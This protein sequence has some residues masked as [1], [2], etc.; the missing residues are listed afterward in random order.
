[1]FEF[2]KNAPFIWTIVALGL[3]VPLLLTVYAVL[4][5]R[6]AKARLERLRRAEDEA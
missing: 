1:M 3:A 5:A 4:R 6:F 2:D